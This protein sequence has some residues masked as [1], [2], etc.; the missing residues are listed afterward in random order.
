VT[1][2]YAGGVVLAEVVRSGF[3]ESRH[4]GSVAVLDASGHLAA[5]V[6][7]VHGALFPRSSNKPMQAVAM[8]RSGLAPGE[9]A[10]LALVAASHAGEPF[11]IER[12]RAMLHAG[13]LSERDLQCPP[14]L[15][16]AESAR[17]EVLRSGGERQRIYMNCSGKHAGMLLA[18]RASGW[19]LESYRDPEHPLQR[20]CRATVEELSGE[21][22]AAVGID[23]CGAPVMAISLVGLARAFLAVV[24]ADPGTAARAVADA[25]RAHPEFMSGT[26]TDDARLMHGLPG[27]LSKG[28]AEGVLAVARPGV[29]AVAMK[30]DDGTTRARL[31][32]LAVALA[33]L[34]GSAALGL[35][36][37]DL[38]RLTEV[39]V[40]GGGERVGQ[41]RA[42]WRG[43]KDH[44]SCC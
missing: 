1:D 13:G 33:R 39:P 23:G 14:D 32:V 22:V 11:H 18:C 3:V 30:I 36:A 7:D 10:D 24:N 8:L 17:A 31:P 12:V 27:L 15:P 34:G 20:A 40:V 19:P 41:V 28:G 35:T 44:A 9:P 26:G 5:S 21:N 2:L 37:T 43:E 6:G 29:G 25:M 38:E 16:L 4:H 42:V